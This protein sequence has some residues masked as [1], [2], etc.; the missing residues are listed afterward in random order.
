MPYDGG[1]TCGRVRFRLNAEPIVTHACHCRQCQRHT[2]SAF[3]MNTVVETGALEV[4]AGE[5]ASTFFDGTSHTAWFCRDCGTYVWSHFGGRFGG[6]RF[7]RVGVMDTPDAFPPDVQIFT[8]TKQPW[9]VLSDAIPS[10]AVTYE[11]EDQLSPESLA[12]LEA[13]S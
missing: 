4:L 9:V 11:W 12:R 7:V 3:M 5:P 1:C 8:E 2:G 13:V 10:F 6:C